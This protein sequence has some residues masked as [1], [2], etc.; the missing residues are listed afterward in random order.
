[1]EAGVTDPPWGEYEKI[2]AKHFYGEFIR[3]SSRIIRPEGSL[4][5]LTSAKGEACESLDKYSF[6]YSFIPIKV[7]GKDTFLICAER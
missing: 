5:F 7:N 4:V 2:N 6:S 1:M 3:E